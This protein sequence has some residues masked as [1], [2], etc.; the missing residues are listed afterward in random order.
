MKP[1]V[2]FSIASIL[3]FLTSAQTGISV[4]EM[5][6]CDSQITN[7][8]NTFDIPGLTMALAKDGKLVYS[9][10]FGNA[11]LNLTE[12]TQPHH[13]FRI[14]SV[15]KP[16]TS[17]GIMK[18]VENG[19]IDLNDKV[20]G[21]GGLLENHWYFTQANIT[22]TRV[23][24]ITVQNLLE[25]TAG[26][27]RNVNCFPSPTA[28]YPWYFSG[29]DPIVAPLHISD[30]FGETYPV[31]EEHLIRYVL[32]KTL[33]YEPGTTYAYSNMGY[34]VLSEIIEEVSGMDYESWMQQEI[35]HPLGIFDMYIGKNRQD[36]R[37][38]R[39]GEYVGNG[40]T[41]LDLY[42][43]G[44]VV[45][46]EYGGFSIEA[47]DGHGGWIATARDLARLLVAVDGFSTKPDILS[48][49]T[50][51]TMTTPS[52]A[53]SY[54]AKGWSV[55][56]ANN[57]WHSGAVDGT[58]SYFVRTSGGYTWAI[59]L[60]KRAV[61]SNSNAF[62]GA[63]DGLGWNCISGTATFPSHDLMEWPSVNASN[64][65]ASNITQNTMELSW[66]NGNGTS[67]LVVAKELTSAMN[68]NSNFDSYPLDG[69]DYA[70]NSTFGLG[71]NLGDGTFVIY[72]G[73]ES[74]TIV[75]GLIE[76]TDYVFRVYE[77]NKNTTTGNNALYLLGNSEELIQN[78]N[79]LSIG[80]ANI[81]NFVDVYP[82]ITDDVVNVEFKNNIGTVQYSVYDIMGKLLLK[83]VLENA[84]NT[85]ETGKLN[86]GMY[87]LKLD[88]AASNASYRFIKK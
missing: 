77:Y 74:T 7:F 11:D 23:Y 35:F 12:V 9:R 44:N 71:D 15:S 3:S 22:D 66:I 43:S 78:T 75:N 10:G 61:G 76:G 68:T 41:T 47:M 65:Q 85:L 70:A 33:N 49:S 16:I 1:L 63:L 6:H 82:S 18:M 34:L 52:G 37:R 54:Y 50:I 2:L 64:L 48:A 60:N 53:A 28:P 5:S 17:I 67:R 36:E 46:W 59:I 29:C 79:A 45:P 84:F 62:W 26:W 20:F 58:A 57:W 14:A 8:M 30:T 4:P 19:S 88:F 86:S 73:T 39:E 81:E 69:T 13:M 80:D 38:E 55:N 87:I 32:E 72:N 42:G 27:D 31:R 51:S 25:H 56:A 40:Y 83:G 24:D 21:T